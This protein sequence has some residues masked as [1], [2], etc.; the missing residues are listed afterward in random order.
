MKGS[1]ALSQGV[2]TAGALAGVALALPRRHPTD[3][4][5]PLLQLHLALALTPML[6]LGV[7]TGLPISCPILGAHIVEEDFQGGPCLPLSPM[8]TLAGTLRQKKPPI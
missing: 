2:I 6:L 3:P 8:T 4:G 1:T 5:Q 7:S